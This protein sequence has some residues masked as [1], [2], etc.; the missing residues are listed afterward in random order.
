MGWISSCVCVLNYNDS[1]LEG[2]GKPTRHE[3]ILIAV[4]SSR[5]MDFDL[6]SP[7]NHMDRLQLLLE[8]GGTR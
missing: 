3:N 5:L 7:V 4:Y 2:T 6:H 1:K 8:R